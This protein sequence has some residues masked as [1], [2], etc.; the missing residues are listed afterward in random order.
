[1]LNLVSGDIQLSPN[2]GFSGFVCF[3]V[4]TSSQM[5][6]PSDAMSFYEYGTSCRGTVETSTSVS[7]VLEDATGYLVKFGVYDTSGR[8]VKEYTF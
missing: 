8:R 3:D 5:L 2:G 6:N 4:S 7:T 1:L